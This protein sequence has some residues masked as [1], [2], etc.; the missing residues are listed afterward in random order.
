[1]QRPLISAVVDAANP[2]CDGRRPWLGSE[3]NEECGEKVRLLTRTGSNAYYAQV[4]SALS[5]PGGRHRLRETVQDHWD[6]L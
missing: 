2:N 1:M 4:E 5:I 6:V 3:G